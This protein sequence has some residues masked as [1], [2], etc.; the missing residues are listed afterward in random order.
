VLTIIQEGSEP[1]YRIEYRDGS[2]IE[3]T[4]ERFLEIVAPVEP[5]TSDPEDVARFNAEVA[6][7]AKVD[8]V[9]IE[10]PT[11]LCAQGV[12]IVDTPGTN[13]LDVA[14]ERITYEFVPR[15]DAVV[16][17]LS[18]RQI[19]SEKELTFLTGR[20]L[21]SD[22]GRLFFVINFKDFLDTPEKQRK[23]IA[24]AKDHLGPVVDEPRIYLI[25]ARDALVQRS[26]SQSRVP[27]MPLEETGVPE[28]EQAAFALKPGEISQPVKTPYGWHIIKVEK[29][30]K[31]IPAVEKARLTQ[32]IVRQRMAQYYQDLLKRANGQNL[33]LPKPS[34]SGQQ[35]APRTQPGPGAVPPPPPSR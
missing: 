1:K 6:N 13:D 22:I 11:A 14:R 5:D 21:K 8:V 35:P 10:Y 7:L 34:A 23:I 12:E 20:I 3:L 9:R 27:P 29:L 33:L 16:F 25:C 15:A 18:A 30:G 28:F 31:D 24:Y 32:I 4:R 17:V 19:L 2:Q 26:R